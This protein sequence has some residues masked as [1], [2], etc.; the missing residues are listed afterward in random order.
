M[1]KNIVF[2][3]FLVCLNL[4]QAQSKIEPP[5]PT[6]C[7]ESTANIEPDYIIYRIVQVKPEYPGGLESF[8]NYINKNLNSNFI[9]GIRKKSIHGRFFVTFIVEQDGKLTS[10]DVLKPELDS[11]TKKEIEKVILN[12]PLWRS[13]QHDG[14]TVRCKMTLPIKINGTNP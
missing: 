8:S 4:M 1:I 7:P 9:E 10:V 14:Y 11:E 12:S 2:I 3:L 5:K 6:L 13:A